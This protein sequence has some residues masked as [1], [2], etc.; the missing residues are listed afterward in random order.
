MNLAATM[1]LNAA[2]FSSSLAQARAG[3][4]GLTGGIAGMLGPLAGLAGVGLSVAGVFSGLKNSL[5]LGDQLYN[6]SKRTG[7]SIDNLQVLQTAFDDTGVG[8]DSVGQTITMLQKA[9]TGV[10]E[11]GEPTNKAFGRL[12]LTIDGLKKMNPTDQLTAIGK[13]VMKIKDP[14]EQTGIA[15]QIFGRSGAAMKQ[16]FADPG[17]IEAARRSLGSMPEVLE[18]SAA[19]FDQVGDGFAHLKTKMGGLFVGIMDQLAP[20]IAPLMEEIDKIDFTKWGQQIGAALAIFVEAFKEGKIGELLALSLKIGIGEGMN[21]LMGTLN[22]TMTAFMT[23]LS[24]PAIWKGLGNSILGIL[25]Q[26]GA[27]LITVFAKPLTILQA[28][29]DWIIQQLYAGI[30]KIPGVGGMLGLNGFK[31][32]SF[33]SLLAGREK[34][35]TFLTNQ[36]ADAKNLGAQFVDAGLA[37]I[38]AGSPAIKDAY[39]IGFEDLGNAIDMSG[40]KAQL[41]DLAGGLLAGADAAAST[42]R[43]TAEAVSGA[44]GGLAALGK[45][46]KIEA[47]D[48]WAKLGMFIGGAGGP[49]VDYAR[50]A[51]V[52]GEQMVKG[53]K[54]VEDKIKPGV[55]AAVWAS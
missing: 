34:E 40:A 45:A 20:Q 26:L 47:P 5:D 48:K 30:A 44:G 52:A 18:R 36:A 2:P 7:E 33:S 22:G 16:F 28:G 49:S 4:S 8:A 25:M 50:R 14:A 42:M 46:D 41:A 35:G 13:A 39:K 38:R 54:R 55:G 23:A 11:S 21:F 37:Q 31:A 12:G 1:S 9:L 17:A 27:G 15:M 3:L 43:S 32:E 10:S 51:A 24:D 29:M 19:L 6:L 53:I